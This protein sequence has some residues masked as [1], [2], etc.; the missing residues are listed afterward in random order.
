[1]FYYLHIYLFSQVVLGAPLLA[2]A[3]FPAALASTDDA[4]AGGTKNV[5]C[6]AGLDPAHSSYDS[7]RLNSIGCEWSRARE[8][9]LCKSMEVKCFLPSSICNWNQHLPLRFEGDRSVAD[10][11][12]NS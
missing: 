12:R 7:L 4:I 5:V 6:D 10:L 11:Y 3:R 2:A 1:M 9:L 8:N